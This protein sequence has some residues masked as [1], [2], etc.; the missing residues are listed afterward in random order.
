MKYFI[1]AGDLSINLLCDSAITREY[2]DLLTDF[3]LE[4]HLS[5]PSHETCTSASLIDHVITSKDISIL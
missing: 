5:E 2:V 3:C 1:I 4:Q